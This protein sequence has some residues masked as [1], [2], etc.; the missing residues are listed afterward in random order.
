MQV[1]IKRA[2]TY[3]YNA[4]A[5]NSYVSKSA[6]VHVLIFISIYALVHLNLHFPLRILVLFG[7][8]TKLEG[9]VWSHCSI[10]EIISHPKIALRCWF[11][12]IRHF[13]LCSFHASFKSH[14]FKVVLQITVIKNVLGNYTNFKSN[15]RWNIF[16]INFL[17][18]VNYTYFTL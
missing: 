18:Q 1:S 14:N 17:K 6:D 15:R 13:S 11:L 2:K 8:G 12:A 3:A 16:F 5:E 9:F 7:T 4:S 10:T